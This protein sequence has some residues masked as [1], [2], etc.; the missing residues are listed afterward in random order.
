MNKFIQLLIIVNIAFTISCSTENIQDRNDYENN[1][2][3]YPR[4]PSELIQQS[5]DEYNDDETRIMI[6]RI[7]NINIE[8]KD[9]IKFL[10]ES[11]DIGNN[12]SSAAATKLSQMGE[13]VVDDL[14]TA[15]DDN[16]KQFRSLWALGKIAS[17]KKEV[18]SIMSNAL[19]DEDFA[20]NHMA[21]M[22]YRNIGCPF[23]GEA[24]YELLKNALEH[25]PNSEYS[26]MV[27]SSIRDCLSQDVIDLIPTVLI[28]QETDP[29]I[30][31]GLNISAVSGPKRTVSE[32]ISVFVSEYPSVR[33]IIRQY[34]EQNDDLNLKGNALYC[35]ALSGCDNEYIV[36]TV[37]DMI[38]IGQVEISDDYIAGGDDLE[39]KEHIELAGMALIAVAA[40][41]DFNEDMVMDVIDNNVEQV[42]LV[43]VY[44]IRYMPDS[45]SAV[46]FIVKYL[47]AKT[48]M[49][50][51]QATKT[52]I[53]MSSHKN[54]KFK[55]AVPVLEKLIETDDWKR[56]G[57]FP[58]RESAGVA[59]DALLKV[60]DFDILE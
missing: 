50:R 24:S 35:M 23:A 55:D 56:D 17:T 42:K 8:D 34:T 40:L 38:K 28:G 45:D 54:Y 5:W 39:L 43:F 49:V 1:H 6:D 29:E 20:I 2:D 33:E 15:V 32:E 18:L 25:G 12:W 59:K 16:Q 47:D 31:P 10:I 60:I 26:I 22:Y 27:L 21:I 48:A 3:S 7:T 44:S 19:K 53:A 41:D 9:S 30:L 4:S 14:I 46:D 13:Q 36:E 52:I 58:I 11:L 57:R 51:L 37:I